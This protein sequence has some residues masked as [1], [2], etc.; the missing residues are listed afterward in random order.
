MDRGHLWSAALGHHAA[1]N[2]ARPA[3]T[4]SEVSSGPGTTGN[5]AGH[6]RPASERT[7]PD[8]GDR[9]QH[10]LGPMAARGAVP[11]RRVA[12]DPLAE[13]ARLRA[14]PVND[15][16][17]ICRPEAG[18]KRAD[19][20]ATSNGA[21]LWRSAHLQ[22]AGAELP[23]PAFRPVATG[24]LRSPAIRPGARLLGRGAVRPLGTGS[25]VQP[26]L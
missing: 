20:S 8:R 3:A 15:P 14:G 12:L 19:G 17:A 18:A 21:V 24:L 10:G 7:T 13:L 11:K 22:C 1:I 6:Y 25:A 9:T 23:V 4:L 26:R 2:P 16:G 5:L